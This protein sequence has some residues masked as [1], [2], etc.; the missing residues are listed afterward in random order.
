VTA[1]RGSEIAL[2]VM[3][4]PV[5]AA[6]APETAL[7][8]D[9]APASCAEIELGAGPAEFN[10]SCVT[11]TWRIAFSLLVRVRKLH[12]IATEQEVPR[13]SQLEIDEECS[14]PS[15]FCRAQMFRE[16]PGPES[17][18]FEVNEP[19]SHGSS[20]LRCFGLCTSPATPSS[21]V[22]ARRC[23]CAAL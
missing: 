12:E 21:P 9:R 20:T 5:R 16:R 1:Q 14:E 2:A 17:I 4:R 22:Y 13:V 23:P 18:L 10:H 7:E 3:I 15:V 6:R 19:I 11:G 8:R